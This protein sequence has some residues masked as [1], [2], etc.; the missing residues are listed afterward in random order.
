MSLQMEPQET[1]PVGDDTAADGMKII[2][3]SRYNFEI[4]EE[5][6]VFIEP[7]N[8]GEFGNFTTV[9]QYFF[10]NGIRLRNEN[11]LI[12]SDCTGVNGVELAFIKGD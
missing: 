10:V 5:I 8:W 4:W 12:C 3:A 11:E 9:E 7:N 6:P 2:C 1:N